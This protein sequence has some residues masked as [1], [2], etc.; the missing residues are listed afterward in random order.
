MAFLWIGLGVPQQ[1]IQDVF[2][3]P[4]V[5]HLNSENNVVPERDNSKSRAVRR[6]ISRL[7]ATYPRSM[8]L[9]IIKQHDALEAWMKKFLVED[10]SA[11]MPSYVDYLCNLHREIRSLLG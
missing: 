11:N 1:W 6:V 2:N 8:K 3:S 4:S 7:N 5:T 9:F 10:R